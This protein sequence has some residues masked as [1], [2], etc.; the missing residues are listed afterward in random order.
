ME[1][2]LNP[3]GTREW[4]ILSSRRSCA[5]IPRSF[6]SLLS[7]FVHTLGKM[8]SSSEII[9]QYAQHLLQATEQIAG[10]RRF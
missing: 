3:Y 5:D 7:K 2:S 10:A 9:R 8:E 1:N 4:R 6:A